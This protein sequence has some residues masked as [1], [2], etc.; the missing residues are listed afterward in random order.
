[1]LRK[2]EEERSA[3]FLIDI[4]ERCNCES[5]RGKQHGEGHE[6]CTPVATQIVAKM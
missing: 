1:M 4:E 3:L 6:M 2:C 5:E